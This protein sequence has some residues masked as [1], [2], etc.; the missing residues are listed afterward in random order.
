LEYTDAQT[1]G[2][3]LLDINLVISLMIEIKYLKT[4]L[5]LQT[6]RLC[7][8]R[9]KRYFKKYFFVSFGVIKNNSQTKNIF[10]LTKKATLVSKN[11]FYF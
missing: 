1:V 7:L 8:F 2:R 10:G 3:E 4:K 5:K 9:R 11:Y 6:L